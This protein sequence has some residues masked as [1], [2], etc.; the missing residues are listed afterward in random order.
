MTTIDPI[1]K[2]LEFHNLNSAT[3]RMLR[4]GNQPGRQDALR[5]RP[6]GI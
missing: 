4:A 5:R 2:Q 6:D 1:R 3:E